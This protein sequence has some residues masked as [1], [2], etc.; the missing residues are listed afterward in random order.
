MTGPDGLTGKA[1]IAEPDGVFR[2][3][4][5][6]TAPVGK[7]D[8]AVRALWS[9]VSIGTEFAVLTG[10]LDWGSFPMVTGYMATGVVVSVGAE[11]SRL[12]RRGH[13]LLPP[14]RRPAAPGHG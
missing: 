13:G 7:D 4:E 11:V 10:K 6:E 12:L 8:I 3:A 9:G 2:L 14:Q 1:L 5:V